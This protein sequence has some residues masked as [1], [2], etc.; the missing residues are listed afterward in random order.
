MPAASSGARMIGS[1]GTDR[2]FASEA[3]AM[4]WAVDGRAKI[5]QQ[6]KS[7]PPSEPRAPSP[8]RPICRC[9]ECGIAENQQPRPFEKVLVNPNTPLANRLGCHGACGVCA[10]C[11]PK[12]VIGPCAA[13]KMNVATSCRYLG[14]FGYICWGCALCLRTL[15]R[16]VPD[17]L[18][19]VVLNHYNCSPPGNFSL[20]DAEAWWL[21]AA[22]ARNCR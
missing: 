16:G 9:I 10:T 19:N 11:R 7:R 17:R 13:C 6:A 15:S 1:D 18:R 5:V 4:L 21:E 20:S 3:A 22:A 2:A 14:G 8:P 12:V